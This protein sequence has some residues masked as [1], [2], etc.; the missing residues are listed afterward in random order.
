MAVNTYNVTSGANFIPEVWA[1]ELSDAVQ[2]ETV[3]AGLVDRSFEPQL[4]FGDIIR[5][6]DSANL[7]VRMKSTDTSATLS[8]ATETQQAITI[9]LH[10]YVAFL[11][12]DILEVQSKYDV[13]ADKTS[14]IAYALTSF[15]EGD[16]TSG[17]ASLPASFSQM[18]GTLGVD[19]TQDDLLSCVAAL[20]RADVPQSGRF[21][22]GG[23]GFKQA[24]LKM[25][26]FTSADFVGTD[27]AKN[28]QVNG[29]FGNIYGSP[30]YI[31]TLADNSPAAANQAYTWYCHKRGVALIV[32]QKT[33]VHEQYT[34][35]ETGWTTLANTIY[36]FAER[37]ILPKTAASTT[38]NDNFNSAL[39]TS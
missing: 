25:S 9:N 7:A 5:I 23:P 38:P 14:K 19:P 37:L 33:Q 6:D 27:A 31:S 32:Q 29:K 15:I 11:V 1:N 16:V 35:L 13:R 26:G 24:V 34:I 28:A 4:K 20:D 36:N 18:Y 2:A 30:V 21:W 17:L 10:A 8:N 3:L 22:Y 39:C 12:E